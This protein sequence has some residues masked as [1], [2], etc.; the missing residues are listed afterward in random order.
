M[1]SPSTEIA[2]LLQTAWNNL[3]FALFSPLQWKKID[4]IRDTFI[5]SIDN[6]ASSTPHRKC[7]HASICRIYSF[8]VGNSTLTPEQT[9]LLLQFFHLRN[10]PHCWFYRLTEP[11]F[12]SLLKIKQNN[13]LTLQWFGHTTFWGEY[14][15]SAGAFTFLI[16]PHDEL[17]L[18]FPSS[19]LYGRYTIWPTSK[20]KLPP[21]NA[22][23]VTHP[24]PD[25]WASSTLTHFLPTTQTIVAP[26]QMK[27][28]VG[29]P[30]DGKSISWLG[31]G[32]Y[33]T[34]QDKKLDGYMRVHALPPPPVCREKCT[35][36]HPFG[37]VISFLSSTFMPNYTIL[38]LGDL[39]CFLEGDYEVGYHAALKQMYPKIDLVLVPIDT[40]KPSRS[41]PYSYQETA[42]SLTAFYYPDVVIPM[43]YG[44]WRF[45]P[46]D[47]L[48]L[49]LKHAEVF[50]HLKAHLTIPD[51][52][53]PILLR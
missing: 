12:P 27:E 21:P 46:E 20:E 17:S 33:V 47:P 9:A 2:E 39:E 13:C 25:H 43:H 8:D 11:L 37:W 15:T 7:L 42:A 16:D 50:P 48:A 31:L 23:L 44:T 14:R 35:T 22:I 51:H 3:S 30:P 26:R 10:N 28:M 41:S 45:H 36:P 49:F 24:A 29:A 1:A 52:G 32:S 18:T 34:V 6:P 5:F 40:E 53:A 19:V 4:V 38:I